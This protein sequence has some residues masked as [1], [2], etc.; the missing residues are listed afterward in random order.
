MH[1]PVNPPAARRF[2]L[3]AAPALA[4]IL[5]LTLGACAAGS[6]GAAPKTVDGG[7][8]TGTPLVATMD[9]HGEV[10]PGD[11][12]GSGEFALW[13]D[14]AQNHV[15]YNLGVA[16]IAAPTAAHVHK[17]GPG[18]SGPPVVRL[19]AP[20]T[21][22]S[23]NCTPVDGALAADLVAHP[24]DYYVNVHTADYPGGAVRGQ[25]AHR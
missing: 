2:A 1:H 7:P 18:V 3:I 11:P 5:A 22:H 17:G 6:S 23:Q 14:T 13:V 4:P 12:D 19:D 16:G 24:A 20:T 9:G 10:P 15:C 8:Y 21:M 25:L